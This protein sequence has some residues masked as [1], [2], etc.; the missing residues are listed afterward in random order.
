[1][2][3]G[4]AR[5]K[6]RGAKLGCILERPGIRD[7]VDTLGGS[8]DVFGESAIRIGAYT[9]INAVSWYK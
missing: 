1:M 4:L 2:P 8:D 9:N 5:G 7:G 3:K 6:W